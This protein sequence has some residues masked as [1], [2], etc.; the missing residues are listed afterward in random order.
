M[1]FCLSLLCVY[2]NYSIP[3]NNGHP[4]T[5]SP[6]QIW[7]S[8]T[9]FFKDK[10]FYLWDLF[11]HNDGTLIYF[12]SQKRDMIS[13]IILL[14]LLPSTSFPI[15]L[16]LTV[17]IHLLNFL[18]LNYRFLACFFF[19]DH[20]FLIEIFLIYDSSDLGNFV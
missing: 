18:L 3:L 1:E 20:L 7:M 13:I 2:S 17:R 12:L 19:S 11:F 16:L 5:C 6:S 9:Y 14:T 4:F 8:N 15:F 10:C